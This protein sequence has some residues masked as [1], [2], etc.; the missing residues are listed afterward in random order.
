MVR[1]LAFFILL[2]I[3]AI[4]PPAFANKQQEKLTIDLNLSK[5]TVWQR[6]QVIITLEVKT[7]DMFAR[8][9]REDFKQ[10]G[11]SIVPFDL[12][13]EE[14]G[15]DLT[16]RY[17]WAVYPFIRGEQQLKLPRIRYRPNSGRP[18]TLSLKPLFLKVLSLPIYVPP[19]MPVGKISLNSQ[20]DNGHIILSRRIQHWNILADSIGVAPQ[21]LPAIT[22]QLRSNNSLQVLPPQRTSK[23]VKTRGGVLS[24]NQ[25][26]LIRSQIY[27]VPL[28]ALSMGILKFPEVSVQYF[29]PELGSCRKL[30]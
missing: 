13:Q 28:K 24:N 17:Q 16:L 26:K 7:K 2:F 3:Q 30:R 27:Q 15:K 14:K 25:T 8:L 6:E 20:W 22:R 29:D 12:E 10:D 4:S 21:T 1:Q 5:E 11:L 18:I 23:I 9:D 19:T